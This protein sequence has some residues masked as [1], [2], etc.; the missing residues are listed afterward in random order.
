[1]N[2]EQLSFFV[3]STLCINCKTCEIACKDA[4]GAAVGQKL[5]RVCTY[6]GGDYPTLVIANLSMACNH[7]EDPQCLAACPVGAYRKR[8]QDGIVVHDPDLCMGCAY[9]TWVCPYGAP[10]YDPGTGK[11]MKCNLCVERL[12]AG[13]APVCVTA[14]PM[15]AIQVMSAGELAQRHDATMAIRNL[16]PPEASRPSARFKVRREMSLE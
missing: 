14:C 4:N 5:R 1:M 2:Q 15:R 10:Q 11:V 12:D 3:D 9:C 8:P 6:E 16:P 7:C 13:E